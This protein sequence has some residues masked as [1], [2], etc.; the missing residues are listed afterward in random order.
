MIPVKWM[1]PECFLVSILSLSPHRLKRSFHVHLH[2]YPFTSYLRLL[3]RL[4]CSVFSLP[5]PLPSARFSFFYFRS[6]SLFTSSFFSPFSHSPVIFTLSLCPFLFFLSPLHFLFLSSRTFF[7][8][9][10]FLLS[11]SSHCTSL[12]NTFYL[13]SQYFFTLS[14]FPSRVFL[15][16][17]SDGLVMFAFHFS[18]VIFFITTNALPLCHFAPQQII[19]LNHL[20]PSLFLSFIN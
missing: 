10:L 17:L 5:L 2:P 9:L 8:F 7:L 6:N 12:L 1:P 19:T 16:H 3:L 18:H 4:R 15:S 14:R 20:N 11:L 13:S